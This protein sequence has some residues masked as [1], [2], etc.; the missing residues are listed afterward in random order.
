MIT[1]HKEQRRR[2]Y[3]VSSVTPAQKLHNEHIAADR[4]IVENF[5]GRLTQ[6]WGRARTV[7]RDDHSHYDEGDDVAIC[8]TNFH[9]QINPLCQQIENT[10]QKFSPY[11]KRVG[12]LESSSIKHK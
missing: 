12:T 2:S 1:P 4:V 6:L 8:L 10:M 7:Y 5:F 11:T 9:I 3:G